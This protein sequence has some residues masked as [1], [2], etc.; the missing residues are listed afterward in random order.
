MP[1]EEL[2][3]DPSLADPLPASPLELIGRWIRE[4]TEA[5][6]RRN[7][8]AMTFA[9]VGADG[10]PSARMV[11]C[12]GYDEANGFVVFYTDRRSRKGLDLEAHPCGAAIFHWDTLQRQV[13]LEG[14][15][16]VSP[17]SE[18]D[19]YFASRPR[20]SQTAAWASHQSESLE[21]RAQLLE[22]LAAQER[23]FQ[24]TE[25]IPRPPYWG[26]YRLYI[27]N[28]ELWVGSEG[29]AHDR[30]LWTRALTASGEGFTGGVWHVRRLQP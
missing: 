12:R 6:F 23:R 22:M 14:P 18:S 5:R 4:A 29:R 30:A 21:S 8:T 17:E 2:P 24:N 9:T 20:L 19:T 15:V 28:A 10:R 7:P 11:L 25:R 16:V 13:R 3:Q 1:F 26:G 27:E